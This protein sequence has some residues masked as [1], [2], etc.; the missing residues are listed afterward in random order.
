MLSGNPWV[1]GLRRL[2]RNK[3]AM[4][5]FGVFLL[6]CTA[7][8]V[9]P[10]L[11][12]YDYFTPD[13][14]A[15]LMPPG[16]EHLFGTN[17]LGR[18]MLSGILYGGRITLHIAFV[19]ASIAMIAGCAIG[20]LSGYFGGLADILI[21]RL[22]DVLSSI[23]VI[24]LVIVAEVVL[25]WGEGNFVYALAISA[26]PQFARLIRAAV[27]NILGQEYIEAA[28]AL[29]ASSM[30]IIRRHVLRNAAVPV[31][32][33][34]AGCFSEAI[35]TSTLLGYLGVGLNP[36][37]PEWGVL[38]YSGKRFMISNPHVILFPCIAVT[39][40]VISLNFFVSGLRDAF[41]PG[42]DV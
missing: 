3:A 15:S 33:H 38:V 6:L 2:C 40:S 25:G 22:V 10:G 32:T 23:P 41:D 29:G 24:L 37:S 5:G 20:L 26:T 17:A 31:V 35:L 7:C 21:S 34:F 1:Y 13:F 28:R 12:H 16:K 27:L 36:P 30:R 14:S 39:V 4:L 18:D 9:M 8:A 11:T 19:S 42:W